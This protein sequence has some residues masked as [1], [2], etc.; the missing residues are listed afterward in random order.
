MGNFDE[1][2]GIF[3]HHDMKKNATRWN[4][5]TKKERK[6]KICVCVSNNTKIDVTN[7]I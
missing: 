4:E 5:K 2:A 6:R 1:S 7:P 3:R